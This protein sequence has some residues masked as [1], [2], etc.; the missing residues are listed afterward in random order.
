MKYQLH[1]TSLVPFWR[2][3]QITYSDHN[4]NKPRYTIKLGM[5]VWIINR[6]LSPG[7]SHDLI[8]MPFFYIYFFNL[9][10]LP[11]THY[12][13]NTRNLMEARQSHTSTR[14]STNPKLSNDISMRGTFSSSERTHAVSKERRKRVWKACER[15]RMKRVKV[16]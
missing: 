13:R 3:S 5:S 11:I 9:V 7:G 6:M 1:S 12:I 14:A 8:L 15:C 10:A 4:S 16:G 2:Q